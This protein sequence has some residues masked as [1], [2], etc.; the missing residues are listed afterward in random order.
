M[1][2]EIN[3]AKTEQKIRTHTTVREQVEREHFGVAMFK[4]FMQSM[5][6]WIKHAR[7]VKVFVVEPGTELS[8]QAL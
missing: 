3:K 2:R 7:V 1:L 6:Q 8:S 5:G 4:D